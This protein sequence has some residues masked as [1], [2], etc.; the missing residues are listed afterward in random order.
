MRKKRKK[1]KREG[2][3]GKAALACA[4]NNQRNLPANYALTPVLSPCFVSLFRF[5]LVPDY[6]AGDR[7]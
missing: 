4:E 6:D 3:G 7:V 2:E 5:V 1:K